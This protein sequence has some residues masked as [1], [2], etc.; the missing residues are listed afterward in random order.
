MKPADSNMLLAKRPENLKQ[1]PQQLIQVR[2]ETSL[3]TTNPPVEFEA[4]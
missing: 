1:R 2:A 4:I 3:L